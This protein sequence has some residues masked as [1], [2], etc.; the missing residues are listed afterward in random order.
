MDL[1]LDVAWL[2]SSDTCLAVTMPLAVVVYDLAVSTRH[3]SVAVML[4][5]ADFVAS[6]AMGKH[7]VAGKEV[8]RLLLM[9]V[10]HT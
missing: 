6:S 9:Q 8:W 10:A 7:L 1:V 5:S 3:P 2:P 4:P